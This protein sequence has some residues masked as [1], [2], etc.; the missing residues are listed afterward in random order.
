MSKHE[1]KQVPIFVDRNDIA[2]CGTC[3]EAMSGIKR[4][5]AGQKDVIHCIYCGQKHVL[6]DGD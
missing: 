2:I 6:M 5:G 4:K 3:N 1:E